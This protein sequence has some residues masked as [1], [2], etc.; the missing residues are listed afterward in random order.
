MVVD[1]FQANLNDIF[2]RLAK[3]QD[4]L[5]SG[6]KLRRPSDDPLGVN[7]ALSVRSSLQLNDQF[8]R[9]IDLSKTWLDTS[10]SA[11]STIS[12]VL[13]RGREL[14][15]QG[16]N[17][18]LTPTDLQ[19]MGDEAAQLVGA[20]L[21]AANTNLLGAYVFSG[22]KTTTK[23]FGDLIPP[24]PPAY[25]GGP[26]Q[27]VVAGGGL[28]G[29]NGNSGATSQ[30]QREI[31]PNLHISINTTGDQL[32]SALNAL[33]KLRDDLQSGISSAVSADIGSLDAGIDQ[34]SQLRADVGAK[35]N[36]FDFAEERLKDFQLQLTK[37]LSQTEDV[38]ITKA[39]SEFALEQTVYQTALKAGASAIQP[40]LLD[41]LR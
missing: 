25:P 9:T 36:R 37:F 32:V 3:V 18:T 7:R 39:A 21:Q 19:S 35:V 5:A 33:V 31:G 26:G 12:E 17:Q 30:M 10:D 24:P 6:Q 23:P 28:Y 20:A 27:P 13:Q 4:Q 8:L 2:L 16:A 41:F 14:A 11:L 29:Y 22:T 38:D 40:S 15:V 1:N 34:V